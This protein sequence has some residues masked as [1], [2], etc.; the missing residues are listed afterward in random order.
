MQLNNKSICYNCGKEGH[1]APQCPEPKCQ[2]ANQAST[3][4]RREDHKGKCRNY[5]NSQGQGQEKGEPGQHA[6][7][8]QQPESIGSLSCPYSTGVLALSVLIYVSRPSS[9]C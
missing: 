8:A 5:R 7:T 1:I 6:K 4:S 9:F 2:Q 3:G